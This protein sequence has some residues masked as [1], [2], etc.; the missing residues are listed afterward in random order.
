MAFSPTL[1]KS[2]LQK[3]VTI[4]FGISGGLPQ[5]SAVFMYHQD[6]LSII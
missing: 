1:H 6:K 4:E 5:E 2:A 3:I